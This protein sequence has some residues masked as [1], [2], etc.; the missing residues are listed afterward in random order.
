MNAI[1]E[2]HASDLKT[3]KAHKD[4]AKGQ[5]TSV[6]FSVVGQLLFVLLESGHAVLPPANRNTSNTATSEL[7]S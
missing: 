7:A 6:G 2:L 5:F 1:V 3:N 4:L